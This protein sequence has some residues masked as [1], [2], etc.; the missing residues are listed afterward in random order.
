MPPGTTLKF[1]G[2]DAALNARLGIAPP[3]NYYAPGQQGW[4]D[5]AVRAGGNPAPAAAPYRPAQAPPGQGAPE[6]IVRG[7]RTGGQVEGARQMLQAAGAPVPSNYWKAN[8]AQAGAAEFAGQLSADNRQR[9]G[10]LADVETTSDP[11][12]EAYWNRADIKTWAAAN[13]ELANKLRVRKGLAAFG[14]DGKPP[15]AAPSA[16]FD[17]GKAFPEPV[18]F[19]PEQQVDFAAAQKAGNL[20]APEAY[21]QSLKAP[22][23]AFNSP[24]APSLSFQQAASLDF[25]IGPNESWQDVANRLAY[26]PATARLS[27]TTVDGSGAGK[28]FAAE[29]KPLQTTWQEAS[30]LQPGTLGP[31]GPTIRASN[32]GGSDSPLNAEESQAVQRAFTGESPDLLDTYLKKSKLQAPSWNASQFEP[33]AAFGS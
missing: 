17:A 5:A 33:S 22:T 18:S 28:A 6:P 32:L 13:P 25:G 30:A 20:V 19:N 15:A 11:G 29:A 14:P 21:Q 7:S 8:P 12:Q 9:N 2:S 3:A 24:A 27:E 16:P 26:N 23:G 31:S 10:P 1:N 4:R